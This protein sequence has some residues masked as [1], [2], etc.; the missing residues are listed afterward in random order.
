MSEE[1]VKPA[2]PGRHEEFFGILNVFVKERQHQEGK[3]CRKASRLR[4]EGREAD[5]PGSIESL[6]D[7]PANRSF[8]SEKRRKAGGGTWK[9]EPE[10]CLTFGKGAV[11]RKSTGEGRDYRCGRC[12]G[13]TLKGGNPMGAGSMKQGCPGIEGSKALRA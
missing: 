12:E 13:K 7:L 3:G 5:R 11:Q 10:L 6:P 9:K 1:K 2:K 8:F 4:A